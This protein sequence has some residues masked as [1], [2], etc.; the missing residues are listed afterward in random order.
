MKQ[1]LLS[2]ETSP[3]LLQHKE[4][5]VAWRP[6]G[7]AAFAA[8]RAEQKPIF[9]SIGYSTCHWCHVMAHESFENDATAALLNEA[10]ISI[11]L[12]REER[13]DIDRVYMA[14]VQ[15]TTGSGGWPMSV[16]LTPDLEPFYGGTYFPPEDRYGR[17]GFPTVLRHLAKVWQEDRERL[18]AH[19]REVIAALR[20]HTAPAAPGSTLPGPEPLRLLWAQA[21]GGYDAEEGGFSPAP[22][23]PRPALLHALLRVEAR[24]PGSGAE[25]REAALHTLRRMSAGGMYD[26]LGGGF[27]RYSVDAY[28]HVPHFE[29]MLYD[30]AQLACTCV[31]AYQLTGEPGFA[32]TARETLGYVLTSLTHPEGGFYAAEDAD[33]P[34]PEDPTQHGEGAFYTWSQA[35]IEA[36]LGPEH[37]PLFL[38]AYGVEPQGN[39][40][41]E[42]DPH[43]E[44]TGKNTLYRAVEDAPLAAALG[45]PEAEVA[46]SLA[47]SRRIL[48][49]ARAQRPRPH[50]DDKILTGWNGLALSAFAR[51]A[52]ALGEPS[53]LA[54]AE[55]A[56]RFLHTHLW[57]GGRLLRS[58]RGTP[59]SAPGFADDYAFLIQG[60]LDLYEAGAEIRWLQ[61]AAELQQ[62]Q[63]TLF[64]DPA[65]GGYYS[66]AEGDPSVLLRLREEH[67]AAE[68]APSSVAAL[69]LLRLGRLLG[70]PAFTQQGD[71][72]LR[73]F[74]EPLARAPHAL[75]QMLVALSFAYSAPTEL[76]L[77]GPVAACAPF[78]SARAARFLPDLTLLHADGGPGQAWLAERLPFLRGLT[79]PSGHSAAAYLCKNFTCQLPAL[80]PEALAESL[81][82]R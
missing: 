58:H 82:I 34:L 68:P 66:T 80:T 25:A 20:E 41:P 32:A 8:A 78:Q 16:F 6:W 64:L 37:A 11:K 3:Y 56:A 60:L 74:A 46:A 43:G 73:A 76:V 75:P 54:A 69:N 30:Q 4:N 70:E 51:A 27:H 40:R 57:H 52:H 13:P 26:H 22:K 14:Y 45:K 63:D 61:W 72:T 18:V 9:L 28:W 49:A 67:D 12:D 79:P 2:A 23:F 15:A 33:S 55:A 36:L 44:L 35:E 1:N 53:F 31:E 21:A 77:A 7:E 42:S 62:V 19:G 81:Y 71:A 59:G 17:P 50:L 65:H 5:P 48:F 29:K 39:A 10:F 38:R 47:Q 24:F